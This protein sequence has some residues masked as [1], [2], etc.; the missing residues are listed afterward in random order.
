MGFLSIRSKLMDIV[1]P[2]KATWDELAMAAAK[3]TPDTKGATVL[4]RQWLDAHPQRAQELVPEGIELL[5]PHLVR[6]ARHKLCSIPVRKARAAREERAQGSNDC[7]LHNTSNRRVGDFNLLRRWGAAAAADG[8]V[9]RF[10]NWAYYSVGDKYLPDCTASDLRDAE[11][12]QASSNKG[13]EVKRLLFKW[14]SERCF[15][16]GDTT[17]PLK[18]LP[19]M[20]AEQLD[21]LVT[22]AERMAERLDAQVSAISHCPPDS[23]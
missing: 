4:M 17:T 5:L 21:K 11:R 23:P 20:S 9:A 10:G 22:E 7:V 14:L 15:P 16:D 19:G 8:V 12:K 18:R 6:D 13:G 3:E 2:N 1:N